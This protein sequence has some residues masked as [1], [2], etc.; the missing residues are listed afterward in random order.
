MKRILAAFTIA[1]V[2]ATAGVI[3]SDRVGI[4]GIVDKVVFEPN[5][6]NPE[7]VQI[8][9]AFAVATRNDR[10]LYDPVQRGYLYFAVPVRLAPLAQGRPNETSLART[11]WKDLKSLAGT[12]RIVAF[13]SR[14][15]QSV[16]VRTD[17]ERP[18]APDRYALGLGVQTIQPDR[19]YAPIKALVAE[20]NRLANRSS[21]RTVSPTFARRILR[22]LRWATFA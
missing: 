17:N 7:R 9:G 2:G 5:A 4:Y 11:E 10:D 13:S 14:F 21:G 1:M 3:A 15:G 22:A 8:W 12:K 16:R 6:E 20:M 18:Q 19:D